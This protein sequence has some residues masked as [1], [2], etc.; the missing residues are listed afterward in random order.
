MGCGP[1]A[2]PTGGSTR[3]A[4]ENIPAYWSTKLRGVRHGGCQPKPLGAGNDYTMFNRINSTAA[5]PL[6][7]GEVSEPQSFLRN[8]RR[9]SDVLCVVSRFLKG[10]D[11]LTNSRRRQPP[12]SQLGPASGVARLCIEPMRHRNCPDCRKR[13]IPTSEPLLITSHASHPLFR[14]RRIYLAAILRQPGRRVL[15]R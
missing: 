7:K 13:P 3:G 4:I 14:S 5:G 2:A 11:D 6:H 9:E 12:A 1:G 8:C 10:S 15:S